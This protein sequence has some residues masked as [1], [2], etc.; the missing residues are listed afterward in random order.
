MS[1]ANSSPTAD[2]APVIIPLYDD[3]DDDED[4]VLAEDHF[5]PVANDAV[6]LEGECTS[7]NA[8]IT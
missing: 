6:S 3:E 1:G 2:I 7:S 8:D 4:A 5:P